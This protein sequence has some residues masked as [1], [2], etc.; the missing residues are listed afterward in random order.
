ML[1]QISILESV[2]DRLQESYKLPVYLDEVKEGFES[3]CF[4]LKALKATSPYTKYLNHNRITIYITFF[5]EKGSTPAEQLYQIQDDLNDMFFKVL[6]I[7]NRALQPEN[8]S[9]EIQGDDSDIVFFSFD[10]N[11]YDGIAKPEPEELMNNLYLTE[12]I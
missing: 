1:Q 11:Y 3:P 2:R 7:K 9:Y 12:R 10:L 4:F 6:F 5:S 8:L